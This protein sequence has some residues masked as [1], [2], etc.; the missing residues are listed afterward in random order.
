MVAVSAVAEFLGWIGRNRWEL[1]HLSL[2]GTLDMRRNLS[3]WR[4]MTGMGC[5]IQSPILMFK[6]VSF[7]VGNL[8]F[9]Q[10]G[11]LTT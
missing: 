1:G 11:G 5:I 7:R 8:G 4:R 2:G 10:T 9:T 6:S 3:D